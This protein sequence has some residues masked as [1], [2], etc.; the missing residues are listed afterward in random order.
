MNTYHIPVMLDEVIQFLDI[1]PDQWYIDCNLGGGGHTQAILD[2][3]GKVLGID[4]DITAIRHVAKNHQLDLIETDQLVYARSEKLIIVQANFLDAATYA[5]KFKIAPVAGILFDL[6]LSSSQ[7]DT[8]ERGFSFQADAPLDMRMDQRLAVSAADLI[9]ALNV[10]E[11][12]ELFQ[13][14]GEETWAKPI[15]KAIV[16]ARQ[17]QLITTTFQLADIIKKVKH[18]R[19]K[20]HPATQVFQALR[21][22]VNDEMNNFRAAL[23]SIWS[24]LDSSGKLVII[25]FHSLEDRWAKN[26]IQQQVQENQGVALTD[27]PLTAEE[28]ELAINPRARSAK[29]RAIQKL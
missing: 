23:P 9:N 3:G 21:I 7:L 27:K 16:A 2:K 10:G 14:Y 6:G 18:S 25:S 20:V 15:A 29:L 26:F 24:V 22:A 17:N 12:A 1:K 11:L 13:K 28:T 19:D 8:A 4:L 5:I